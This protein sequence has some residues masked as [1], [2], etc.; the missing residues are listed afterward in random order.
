MNIPVIVLLGFA[1][2]TV[3]TLFGSIGIYRWRRILTGRTAI[4]EWRADLPQGSE[5]YKRAMRAHMNCVENLP[6]YTALVVALVATG[7]HS[8]TIDRLAIAI[9]GARIGQTL[10]HI[11]LPPTNAAA[12]FRF[13]LFFAQAA[14]MIVMGVLIA[15][16]SF[17]KA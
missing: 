3:L 4:N 2:W 8:V 15:A 12:S 9:L 14:C 7:V 17:H 6:V 1:A 5:W 13:A 10:V 16:A 11:A